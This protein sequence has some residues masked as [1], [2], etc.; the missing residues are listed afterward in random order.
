VQAGDGAREDR[1]KGDQ[2]GQGYDRPFGMVD[3]RPD[4]HQR[5]DRHHRR[6]LDHRGEGTHGALQQGVKAD[7]HGQQLGGEAGDHQGGESGRE[8]PPGG[9][10]QGREIRR[11]RPCDLGRRR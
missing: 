10:R 6:D 8:R 2:H 7:H 1:E 11:K 5:R 4:Q 9:L 3:P